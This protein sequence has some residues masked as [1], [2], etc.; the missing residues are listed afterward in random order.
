MTRF[1]LRAVSSKDRSG[2]R[3]LMFAKDQNSAYKEAQ[4]AIEC[5]FA[6]EITILSLENFYVNVEDDDDNLLFTLSSSAKRMSA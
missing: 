5:L 4:A 3:K 6:S 2:G 1:Y